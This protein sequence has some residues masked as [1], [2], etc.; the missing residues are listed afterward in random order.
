MKNTTKLLI[1]LI[2]S[3]I[4]LIVFVTVAALVPA[5]TDAY[6][7]LAIIDTAF[8]LLFFLSYIFELTW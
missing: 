2:V 8:C 3:A 1:A 6:E 7:F 5:L 4:L